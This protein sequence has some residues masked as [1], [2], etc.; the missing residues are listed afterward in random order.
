MFIRIPVSIVFDCVPSIYSVGPE[1]NAVS[2]I[3]IISLS[4][5]I[6]SIDRSSFK[7]SFGRSSSLPAD[8]LDDCDSAARAETRFFMSMSA[9]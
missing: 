4:L 2:T 8:Q 3:I 7:S 1:S 6:L 9:S 5:T